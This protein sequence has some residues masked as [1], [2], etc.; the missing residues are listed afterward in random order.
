MLRRTK[1]ESRAFVS[2]PGSRF[3]QK[4][5]GEVQL[6]GTIKLVD[7]EVVDIQ[8][9]MNAEYP[10][11]TIENILRNSNPLESFA[12]DGLHSIDALE[13]PTTLAEFMQ[14]QIDQRT[15]FESLSPEVRSKFGNDFNQFLATAGSDEWLSKLGV[16]IEEPDASLNPVK[17]LNPVE[18]SVKGGVSSES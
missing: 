18:T 4:R 3:Y 1:E 10:S 14:F 12:D 16:V 6:D 8:E 2:S 13:L 11:T 15:R 9:Q 7:D 17:P 5:H